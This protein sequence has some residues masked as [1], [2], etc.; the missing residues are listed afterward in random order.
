LEGLAATN[1]LVEQAQRH[2]NNDDANNKNNGV[3]VLRDELY[4]VATDDRQRQTLQ[5]TAV[6]FPAMAKWLEPVELRTVLDTSSRPTQQQ[7][8]DDKEDIMDAP[9]TTAVLNDW[10]A[11]QGALRLS[12]GC[13]VIH[14]PSYLQGLWRACEDLANHSSSTVQWTLADG[15]FDTASAAAGDDNKNVTTTTT[16]TATTTTIYCVGATSCK[17]LEARFGLSL[18]VQLVRGHSVEFRGH[19][20]HAMLSGKYISPTVDENVTLIGATHDFQIHQ[21]RTVDDIIRE[22]QERTAHMC[23]WNINEAHPIHRITA[24]VRVQSS[25][26]PL[27]RRPIVGRIGAGSSNDPSSFSSWIF[28]GL[29]SRGLLYHGIY[30]EKLARAI[31]AD[32]ED[33]LLQDC[34]DTLW[35]KTR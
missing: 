20:P 28:T 19:V 35:W 29:S 26:G 24:G 27:G 18:P 9:T 34:P 23:T 10:D 22:L 31:W 16:T 1:A 12:N 13:Q 5:Q 30:G 32:N 15:L 4:R 8:D 6:Q 17:A 25:R 14:V 11:I 33:E 3:V 21:E 7:S 2:Y